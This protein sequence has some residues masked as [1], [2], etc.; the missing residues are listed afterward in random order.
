MTKI[1]VIFTT[2]GTSGGFFRGLCFQIL[3]V[4]A[5]RAHSRCP[6]PWN[7]ENSVYVYNYGGWAFS[8]FCVNQLKW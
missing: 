2:P 3:R 4:H 5:Y 7:D 1:L 6:N 8:F